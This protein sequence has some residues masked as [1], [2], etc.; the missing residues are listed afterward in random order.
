MDGISTTLK[1]NTYYWLDW[2]SLYI[3]FLNNT[4]SFPA[5]VATIKKYWA[6]AKKLHEWKEIVNLQY[7]IFFPT[8]V[9]FLLWTI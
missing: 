1:R 4:F 3:P 9:D 7:T 6:Y 5:Q 8:F 2:N